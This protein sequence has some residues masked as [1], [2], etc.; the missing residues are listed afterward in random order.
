LIHLICASWV[1]RITG[2]NHKCRLRW[3]RRRRWGRKEGR[4]GFVTKEGDYM[5][6]RHSNI[7]GHHPT[8]VLLEYSIYHS[9]HTYTLLFRDLCKKGARPKSCQ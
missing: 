8:L 1:A 5:L 7:G 6:N 2:M 9:T 3:G 4:I